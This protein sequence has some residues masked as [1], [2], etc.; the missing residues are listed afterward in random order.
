VDFIEC[1]PPDFWPLISPLRKL[2]AERVSVG[3]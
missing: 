1:P 2:A 3:F